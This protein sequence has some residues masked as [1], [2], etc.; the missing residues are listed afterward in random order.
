MNARGH[1]ISGMD[2]AGQLRWP[3]ES[4]LAA[5]EARRRRESALVEASIRS[6][7]AVLVY[8]TEQQRSS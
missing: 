3:R 7:T 5:A 4:T 8:P 1:E 2:R 6:R